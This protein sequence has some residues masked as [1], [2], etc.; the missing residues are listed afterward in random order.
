MYTV[1]Q[2][3][4]KKNIYKTYTLN[5]LCIELKKSQYY[6]EIDKQKNYIFFGVIR[7]YFDIDSDNDVDDDDVSDTYKHISN[8]FLS[9]DIKLNYEDFKY[10]NNH[11]DYIYY[12]IP[13]INC[14]FDVMEKIYKLLRQENIFYEYY[15]K[16]INNVECVVQGN[17]EDFVIEHIP[18]YS[19]CIS[20]MYD[21][22]DININK[23]MLRCVFGN[24]RSYAKI[25]KDNIELYYSYGNWYV[26]NNKWI[27]D[28]INKY[29]DNNLIQLC[30]QLKNEI[31][32][33]NYID[34]Y[35]CDIK[36]NRDYIIYELKFM[37]IKFNFDNNYSL[38]GFTN[39]VYDMKERIFREMKKDDLITMDVGYD[40]V[41][42]PKY[43]YELM[44]IIKQILPN[45]KYRNYLLKV[46]SN[47]LLGKSHNN[48]FFLIG[49]KSKNILLNLLQYTLGLYAQNESIKCILNRS[50]NYE[51]INKLKRKRV[52]IFN[53]MTKKDKIFSHILNEF[54]NSTLFV[55]CNQL[56]TKLSFNYKTIIFTSNYESDDILYEK[57]IMSFM[58]ILLNN[59][60]NEPDELEE[61]KINNDPYS[62]FIVKHIV[63]SVGDKISWLDLYTLFIEKNPQI[64]ESKGLILSNFIRK[65]FNTNY[66]QMNING[67]KRCGWVDFKLLY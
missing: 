20:E 11:Q 42:N 3:I 25:L 39:G 7:R 10:H 58:K 9:M 46:F 26:Y 22:I 8:F 35:I 23:K 61:H 2:Y 65:V 32:T 29:I 38:I 15:Y 28:D 43:V 54:N 12:T 17:I 48:I 52:I 59:L 5:E 50:L 13:K 24:Y 51:L 57:Y 37:C 47:C 34:A 41:D 49:N 55:N 56:P 33:N 53:D 30:E 62:E 66:A 60:D 6:C 44:D 40:Y 36:N 64:N 31:T 19:I 21:Y 1:Y 45:E 63:R 14:S 16:L 18:E 27:I 67:K 4:N